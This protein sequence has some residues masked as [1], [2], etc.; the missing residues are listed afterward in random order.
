MKILKYQYGNPIEE[1]GSKW[2]DRLQ[3]S[4]RS[5]VL[6]KWNATGKKPKSE[7]SKEYTKRRVKEETK[8][9]WRSDAADIAHGIGEGVLVLHP[10]TAIPYYGG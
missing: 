1:W 8:R 7:S 4:A 10:Y 9:T 3:P 6:Q 5:K 2:K